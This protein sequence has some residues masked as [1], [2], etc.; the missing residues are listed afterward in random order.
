[1]G[2]LDFLRNIFSGSAGE[3]GPA[4]RGG[5][6]R[7]SSRNR[8]PTTSPISPETLQGD[9]GPGR[10]FQKLM[11]R[12][13]LRQTRVCRLMHSRNAYASFTIAKR[14]GA[15]RQILAPCRSL[16]HIQRRILYR[17]LEPL[18]KHDAAHGFRRRRSIL[19]NAA[20]HA[21]KELVLSVDLADFFPSISSKRVYG[22][23]RALKWPQGLAS[24][25]TRL[26]TWQGTLPQGAPTSPALANLI[27]RRLD[28]RL[29]GLA[30]KR[31]L[32]YTRYADDLTFSGAAQQARQAF[33]M[34]KRIVEE[35]GFKL[36]EGKTRFMRRGRRQTVTGL[37]VN[38]QAGVPRRYRRQIR[39]ALH[40]IQTGRLSFSSPAERSAV[41]QQLQ[42]HVNFIRSIR[43]EHAAPLEAALA[44]LEAAS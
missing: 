30:R 24:V 40:N 16:K 41:L 25:L 31:G 10:P 37:V 42:G 13:G 2:L 35:E 39:A 27:A 1:M 8:Q 15:V 32:A 44:E 36:S 9:A 4:A 19:T 43:P 6:R 5:A 29:E 7:R 23:L 18:D 20:V 38:D 17:V 22:L 26:T 28:R 34:I 12:M 21:G 3:P 33:P 11:S 14:D